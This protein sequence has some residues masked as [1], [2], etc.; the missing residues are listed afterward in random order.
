MRLSLF[1]FLEFAEKTVS[2]YFT[3]I[4]I[5]INMD[6]MELRFDMLVSR[7]TVAVE[8]VLDLLFTEVCSTLPIRLVTFN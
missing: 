7:V 3:A 4:C 2:A 8:I 5:A 6:L 1:L